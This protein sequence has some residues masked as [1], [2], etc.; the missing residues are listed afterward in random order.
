MKK[1][2]QKPAMQVINIEPATMCAGSVDSI[3][4]NADMK[5]GGAGSGHARGREGGGY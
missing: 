5:Y 1:N 2:Y 4:G 3:G